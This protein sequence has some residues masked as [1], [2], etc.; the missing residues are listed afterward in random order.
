[1]NWYIGMAEHIQLERHR[2]YRQILNLILGGEI[3]LN[4]SLS[5]RRLS[6]R[7][8]IGRTPIREALRDLARDGILEVRPARGTYVRPMYVEDVRE[9]YQIRQSIEG[10]AARLAAERG[11]NDRLRALGDMFRDMIERPDAHTTSVTYGTGVE[12]HLEIFRSAGNRNLLEM[13]EPLR[14]RFRL[15]LRAPRFLGHSRVPE[16]VSEHLAILD[17]IERGD[18]AEADRLIGIHLANGLEARLRIFDG[19]RQS[20]PDDAVATDA[21]PARRTVT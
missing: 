12:F 7:L 4:A 19:L 1:M 17:A 18:A 13:Y 10:L 16:S 6:E 14:L 3:D 15:A 11:P 21:A 20:R 8:E 5:E 9:I 2:A